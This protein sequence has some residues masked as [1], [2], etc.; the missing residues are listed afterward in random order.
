[1]NSFDW[2]WGYIAN[3]LS[4]F[5]LVYWGTRSRSKQTTLLQLELQKNS[6]FFWWNINC[7]DIY[8]QSFWIMAVVKTIHSNQPIFHIKVP[9]KQWKTMYK[10]KKRNSQKIVE[11]LCDARDHNVNIVVGDDDDGFIGGRTQLMW[12]M[13]WSEVRWANFSPTLIKFQEEEDML[14]LVK[15]SIVSGVDQ[16]WLLLYWEIHTWEVTWSRW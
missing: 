1:M 4:G 10:L 16:V 8:W 5:L 7:S 12:L 15:R 14:I 6:N 2:I 3:C 9:E 11:V 13:G